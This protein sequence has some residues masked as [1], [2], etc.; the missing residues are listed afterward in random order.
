VAAPWQ[1]A[2]VQPSDHV[3]QQRRTPGHKPGIEEACQYL[4]VVGSQ[5]HAIAYGTE[6]M[7]E[8]EPL[9]P[10]GQEECLRKVDGLRWNTT[11]A[12]DQDVDVRGGAKLL[13][14]VTPDSHQLCKPQPEIRIQ[15]TAVG[16]FE[17]KSIGGR[18]CQPFS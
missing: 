7:P 2:L 13:P 4:V 18:L 16:V 9:I 14:P 15:Q 11:V 8:G 12:K 5:L 6:T 3:F 1:H 10:Q 17:R